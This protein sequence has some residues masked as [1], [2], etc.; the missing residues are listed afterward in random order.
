MPL[1]KSISCE[2]YVDIN[3]TGLSWSLRVWP[4]EK[5]DNWMWDVYIVCYYQIIVLIRLYSLSWIIYF[6]Y[7][8][9]AYSR[10]VNMLIQ[11]FLFT[12]TAMII[13]HCVSSLLSSGCTR[14][15]QHIAILGWKPD[16]DSICHAKKHNTLYA[17]S[18]LMYLHWVSDNF[19][20][21]FILTRNVN[22]N[23]EQILT[24]CIK[25]MLLLLSCIIVLVSGSL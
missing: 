17:W 22:F 2:G 14:H 12:D 5:D 21:Y 8:P 16:N 10:V 19:V 1:Q 24:E 6:Y 13:V 18:S 15:I 7:R 23:N 25:S 9:T 20:S 11:V 4:L 3:S